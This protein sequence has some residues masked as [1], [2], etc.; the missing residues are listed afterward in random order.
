MSEGEEVAIIKRR[1]KYWNFILS[2]GIATHSKL[3]PSHLPFFS[4]ISAVLFLSILF[5]M[6]KAALHFTPYYYQSKRNRDSDGP[7]CSP[8]LKFVAA[9]VIS[10]T[11]SPVPSPWHLLG[12]RCARRTAEETTGI[13]NEEGSCARIHAPAPAC[14]KR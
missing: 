4:L 10:S 12:C 8:H 5:I 6:Q 14:L 13:L 7:M 2:V 9:A 11:S 3:P 1:K